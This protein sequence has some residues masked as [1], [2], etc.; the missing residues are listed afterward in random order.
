VHRFAGSRGAGHIRQPQW[1][2]LVFWFFMALFPFSGH[3]SRIAPGVHDGVLSRI[4]AKH[5]EI[6]AGN[7][8]VIRVEELKATPAL[9]LFHKPPLNSKT[10]AIHGFLLARHNLRFPKKLRLGFQRP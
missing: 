6:N 3:I 4:I 5:A 1:A 7:E 2:Q 9:N 10:Y 8:E